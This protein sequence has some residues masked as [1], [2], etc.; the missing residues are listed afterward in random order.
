MKDRVNSFNEELE[1]FG[2]EIANASM[3]W[4]RCLHTYGSRAWLAQH[5]L[6]PLFIML[7]LAPWLISLTQQTLPDV[8]MPFQRIKAWGGW[9]VNGLHHSS[10]AFS[11]ICPL[12]VWRQSFQGKLDYLNPLL[13]LQL[14]PLDILAPHPSFFL[15][16]YSR[17]I[18]PF[19]SNHKH[20]S[21]DSTMLS[22]RLCHWFHCIGST[23][24]LP[25]L[26]PALPPD[27]LTTTYCRSGPLNL[28]PSPLEVILQPSHHSDHHNPQ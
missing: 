16:T 17:L 23:S 7:K 15:S 4:C 28:P 14:L 12:Q 19:Y 18:Q 11:K 3:R 8:Q 22:G 20:R 26:I 25:H 5:D 21:F 10:S 6:S 13:F 2:Q 1:L 9:F 24:P 27:V